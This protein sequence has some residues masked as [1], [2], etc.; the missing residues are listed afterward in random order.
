MLTQ[1]GGIQGSQHGAK[2]TSQVQGSKGFAPTG[3]RIVVSSEALSIRNHHGQADAIDSPEE[4]ALVNGGTEGKA[5]RHDA[6][7]R[8]AERNNPNAVVI[9]TC[10]QNTAFSTAHQAITHSGECICSL[11]AAV[12]LT[13]VL[14]AGTATAWRRPEGGCRLWIVVSSQACCTCSDPQ[15]S[16]YQGSHPVVMLWPV[17]GPWIALDIPVALEWP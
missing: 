3:L 10:K 1:I 14:A 2:G 6:P 15:V 4:V 16:A 8:T 12:C 7:Y 9:V 13:V 5:G 11:L 17:R